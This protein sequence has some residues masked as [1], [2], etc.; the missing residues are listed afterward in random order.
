MK[1]TLLAL[2]FLG[3]AS[4][5][6][7]QRLSTVGIPAFEAE[8]VSPADAASAARQVIDELKSWGA[9]T[10]LEGDE[11]DGAEYIVRGKLSRQGAA[12]VL[13]AVTVETR[14][15]RTLN[16]AKEQGAS[17]SGISIFSFCTQVIE[18][19]PYPNYLLGKWQSVIS[20]PEG[21]LVCVI[22]FRTGRVVR[23]ERYDTW[24]RRQ[25]NA[26]KYEGYGSGEYSYAGYVRRT[27][28]IR[29]AQGNSRQS[30]VDATV[31]VNLKL[32]ETL[33]E[34]KT[35]GQ[36]GLRLLFDDSRTSFEFVN[37][38]LPCGHNYDGAAVYPSA[39]A[40]FTRF[41]RIQ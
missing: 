35:V 15:K 24:E 14:S 26:L 12:L 13:S 38:G 23:V 34:Q 27:M 39:T 33:P 8:G 11:A 7:A 37:G 25:N 22:E 29:D 19:V 6:F 32:E 10:I 20:M 28:N 41:T 5:A 40:A 4:G 36:S 17:L 3:L 1:K 2:V 18:N 9:L 21:P 31:G 16:E 30:P